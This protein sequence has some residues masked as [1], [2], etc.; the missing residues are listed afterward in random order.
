MNKRI[1]VGIYISERVQH[2]PDVQ[3]TLTEFGCQIKTRLG[4]HEVSDNLC[5]P[6]GLLLLEMHGDE[7]EIRKMEKALSGI[8]GVEVKEMVFGA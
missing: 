3:K 4:L 8:A 1:I 6:N 5:S 7:N 2:V